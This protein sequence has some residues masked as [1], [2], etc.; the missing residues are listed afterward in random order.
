[1]AAPSRSGI[2]RS[3][4]VA[5]G[6]AIGIMIANVPQLEPTENAM[7]ADVMKTSGASSG[8]ATVAPTTFAT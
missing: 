8:S 1:M 5:I 6:I 2:G 3:S 7:K 4:V